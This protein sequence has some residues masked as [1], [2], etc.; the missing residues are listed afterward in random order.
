MI[1]SISP[2]ELHAELRGQ[3]PPTIIDVRE[4]YELKI[5][6]LKNT[7]HIPLA[8]LPGHVEELTKDKKYVVMCRVGGR[9]AQ[10]TSYLIQAGFAN[11]RNLTT[12]INGWAKTVDTSMQ[13]Y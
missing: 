4:A 7:V 13:E 8:Q 5:S 2:K 1:P 6:T 3:N 11:V 12:G 9:S 10:A